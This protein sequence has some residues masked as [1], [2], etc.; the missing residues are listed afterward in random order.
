MHIPHVPAIFDSGSESLITMCEHVER[1]PHVVIYA[2]FQDM[3]RSEASQPPEPPRNTSE[4]S[5][6]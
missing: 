3:L 6:I 2:T 4:P 5:V 1:C